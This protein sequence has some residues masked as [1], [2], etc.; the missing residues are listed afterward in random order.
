MWFANARK[1]IRFL[2]VVC[3]CKKNDMVFACGFQIQKKQYGFCMWFANARKTIWFSHVVCKCKKNDMV[4]ACGLQI[5]N[6]KDM[7]FACDRYANGKIKLYGYCMCFVTIL[8][9]IIRLHLTIMN[10][11]IGTII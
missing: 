3:K 6:K 10:H 11:N 7:I 5:K 2:H 8:L 9:I 1:M 4:F